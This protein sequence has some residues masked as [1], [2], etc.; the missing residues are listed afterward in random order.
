MKTGPRVCP[1]CHRENDPALIA[2]WKCGTVFDPKAGEE[3][4]EPARTSLVPAF[5]LVCVL[6]TALFVL[7]RYLTPIFSGKPKA[8][9]TAEVKEREPAPVKPSEPWKVQTTQKLEKIYPALGGPGGYH[10]L[11]TNL[12]QPLTSRESATLYFNGLIG[13]YLRSN[14][15]AALLEKNELMLGDQYRAVE[16]KIGFS[17][18]EGGRM[19]PFVHHAIAAVA[20]GKA[21][22]VSAD[23]PRAQS[24][25]GAVMRENLLSSIR[26][27][28]KPGPVDRT[29]Y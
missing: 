18:P 13:S 16:Y 29:P 12:P 3:R 7:S 21:Y 23:A 27:A 26:A 6:L 25:D 15:G 17:Y 9:D 2:C 10:L 8:G 22:A 14:E 20:G 28:E 5:V 11:V 19:Q 4:A 24:E 1:A